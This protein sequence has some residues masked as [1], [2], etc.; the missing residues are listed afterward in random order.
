MHFTSKQPEGIR[1]GQTLHIKLNLSDQKEAITI[2][3]GGFYQSTGGQWVFVVNGNSATKRNIKL[4]Q[5]NSQSFEVLEGLKP[6]EKVITSSYDNYG[7]V[8][9][10][11]LN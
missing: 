7:D 3:R 6:G 11:I 5:Q 10:L 2:D 1:R 8:E 4:G 9:K